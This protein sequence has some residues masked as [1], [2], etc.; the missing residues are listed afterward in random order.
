M[1]IGLSSDLRELESFSLRDI[2]GKVRRKDLDALRSDTRRIIYSAFTSPR[3]E[4]ALAVAVLQVLERIAE[5]FPTQGRDADVGASRGFDL[6][7]IDDSSRDLLGISI[8]DIVAGIPGE[9]R[10]IHIESI[11]QDGLLYRFNQYRSSLADTLKTEDVKSLWN[12][13]PF[14]SRLRQRNRNG[15]RHE[16]VVTD[17]FT[18]RVVFHG[19]P[20]QNIASIVRSG[21]LDGDHNMWNQGIYTSQSAAYALSYAEGQELRTPLGKLPSMRL[22][23]CAAIEAR[24]Y[25]GDSLSVHSGLQDGYDS[26]FD[27]SY[28]HIFFAKEGLLPCYVI[29]L[30]LG[31]DA[32]KEAV[33]ACQKDAYSYHNTPKGK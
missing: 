20:V 17:M 30:D 8:Q 21:F 24:T 26:H 4:T 11:I 14:S 25:I 19:T 29:H 23:V 15:I 16:E 1:D 28:D 9:F 31:A 22:I 12:K 18:P 7:S 10:V 27:G 33:M 13:L 6:S 2:E 32:A 5:L 3:S